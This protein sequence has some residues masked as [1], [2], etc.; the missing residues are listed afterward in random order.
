MK[1]GYFSFRLVPIVQPHSVEDVF[2][3]F[4]DA[5]PTGFGLLGLGKVHQISAP[6]SGCKPLKRLGQRAIFIQCSLKFFGDVIRSRRFQLRFFTRG[7]I[8]N[9]LLKELHQ[10]RLRGLDLLCGGEPHLPRRLAV[11]AR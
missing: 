1:G 6:A 2:S 7:F 11:A 10:N 5:G 9:G 8:G 3:R 4:F